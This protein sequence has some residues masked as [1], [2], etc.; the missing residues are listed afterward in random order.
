MKNTF[1]LILVLLL[2]ACSSDENLTVQE[3]ALGSRSIAPID[4]SVSNPT[5]LTDWENCN[6]IILNEVSGGGQAKIVAAPWA[7]GVST[8]LNYEFR[9]DIKKADGWKMLFHTFCQQNVDELQTYMCLYNIFTGYMKFFYYSDRA[10]IGTKTMWNIS[11]ATSGN[12]QGLF[13]D[14]AYFSQPINNPSYSVWT[15]ML[16]N[17]VNSDNT[18]VSRGWNGF[19]FRVGEYR[20]QVLTSFLNISAYNSLF[21]TYN[22]FGE[23]TSTTTGKITTINST[24]KSILDNA[25]VGG[26]LNQYGEQ[27]KETVN[28][29]AKKILPEKKFLGIDL[30]GIFTG[31]DNNNYV[32]A[33][34]AGL[35]LVFGKFLSKSKTTYSVSEVDLKTFGTL[36]LDG[37]SSTSMTSNVAPF[38]FNFNK[39]L[40]YSNNAARLADDNMALLSKESGTPLQLGVWNLR[41]KPIIYYDRYIKYEPQMEPDVEAPSIDFHGTYRYPNTSAGPLEVVFNPMIQPYIKNYSTTVG[42][43]DVVGGNRKLE[44]KNKA[45]IQY[46]VHNKLNTM[47]DINVYGI[48]EQRAQ[49]SV[50]GMVELPAGVTLN[51]GTQ[52]YLD[53][54][55]AASGYV[56]AVVTLTMDIEYMGQ[57]FSVTESRVYDVE[58]KPNPRGTS[59]AAANNPPYTFVV[60]HSN[61]YGFD[62]ITVN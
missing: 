40:D 47:N 5:L 55:T 30:R 34:K 22:F 37:N 29:F 39:V 48:G 9:K 17:E 4:P 21:S 61:Y 56:A 41:N 26:A 10:D 24:S 57:Q 31:L 20:P 14:E 11:A 25:L 62:F 36:K 27:A 23:E 38:S 6:T 50:F 32:D 43:I 54:G 12:C 45:V 42:M 33:I 2:A 1:L 60:N 19:Q 28:S 51:S 35:G 58:Y 15:L 49:G 13:D 52:Y 44:H 18:G 59:L 16:K 46:D 7:D 53:W 8:S 3:P